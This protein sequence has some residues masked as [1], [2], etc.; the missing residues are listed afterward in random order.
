MQI[1]T[2]KNDKVYAITYTAEASIF[3]SYL[4]A[5]QKMI[6]S[7]EITNVLTT[8]KEQERPQQQ[9]QQKEQTSGKTST[10]TTNASSGGIPWL[11]R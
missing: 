9:Q 6:D 11:P 3:P 2:I 8:A 10:S 1:Y 5:V 7:L 4:P